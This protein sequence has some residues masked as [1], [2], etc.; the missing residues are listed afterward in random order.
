MSFNNFKALPLSISNLERLDDFKGVLNKLSES[1]DGFEELSFVGNPCCS[2]YPLDVNVC[3]D[4]DYAFCGKDCLFLSTQTQWGCFSGSGAK[5]AASFF[6]QFRLSSRPKGAV[7][8][9]HSKMFHKDLW[10]VGICVSLEINSLWF[11]S[12]QNQPYTSFIV[13]KGRPMT[14]SRDGR[15]SLNLGLSYVCAL[16]R[17][18]E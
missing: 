5:V 16:G 17:L 3:Q 4:R 1:T 9:L 13:R 15:A 2:I 10:A 6:E 14:V 12:T 18:E 7:D 8:K 11:A